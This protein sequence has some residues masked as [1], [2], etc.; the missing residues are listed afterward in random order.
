MVVHRSGT[1]GRAKL[2]LG[3]LLLGYA[4]IEAIA[5]APRSPLVPPL[6]AGVGVPAWSARLA[7]LVPLDRLGP[8][9]LT[10][11]T[12]GV[13]VGLIGAFALLLIEAWSGRVRLALVLGTAAAAMAFVS[14]GPLLL[15]RDVY[16][17]AAYGRI[18]ALHGVNP[19]VVRPSSFPTDPFT[20]V[21]APQWVRTP[22]LYGPAFTLLSAAIA[23]LWS[24][25]P[26]GTIVAFKVVAGLAMLAA[27]GMIA[28]AGRAWRPGGGALAAAAVG[29]NPV[30]VV[31]TVGGAHNDA[32]LA[33]CLA[34]AALMAGTS[35]RDRASGSRGI[36]VSSLGVTVVLTLGAFVKVFGAVPL[37][38]WVWAVIRTARGE[39]RFRVAAEHI[40]AAVALGLAVSLPFLAGTH[41]FHWLA[42]TST[43]EGWASGPRLV[44]RGAEALGRAIAGQ[45]LGD[46]FAR[47]TDAAFLVLFAAILW[48]V[49]LRRESGSAGADWAIALLLLALALP[50]LVPWYAAWFVVLLPLGEDEALLWLG[51]A[52]GGLLALTGVPADPAVASGLWHSMMLAVHYVG[53]PIMLA[54]LGVCVWRA[55]GVTSWRRHTVDAG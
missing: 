35:V 36:A 32:I 50:Y 18:V 9:A 51:V 24:S 45:S 7:R 41:T 42:T 16:S 53:A 48:R 25:S 55:I 46:A 21:A 54:L 38:I 31:H 3:I 52:A 22:S 11:I 34:G 15:S 13:L 14:V 20:L 6:P 26:S 4:V 44:A 28:A 33:M 40:G 49:L 12:I 27:T 47:T 10:A 17:Y 5:G 23:R 19:Y 39:A 43:V 30:I 2:A 37:L 1:S 8:S 29:L